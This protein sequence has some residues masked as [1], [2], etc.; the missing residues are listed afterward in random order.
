MKIGIHHREGSF[1]DGWILYC[2]TNNIPF[3]IVDAY[4]TTI[5]EDLNDCTAFL[6]HHHHTDPRDILFAK[7]L[8]YSLETKGLSVFPNFKT[9][10]HFD[11]K[12]AQKYLLEAMDAPLVPSY[13]FY[14]RKKALEWSSNTTYPKVFK[15]K[16]GASSTGVYLARNKSQA[17][18]FINKIFKRGIKQNNTFRNFLELVKGFIHNKNSFVLALKSFV[19]LFFPSEFTKIQGKE[20][21]YAYFQE[22]MPNNKFDTRLI[23]IGNKAY[24]MNRL[25]RENDFRASGSAKFDYAPIP[26][27]VLKIGFDIARK[28]GLQSVAFDFI[29][30]ENGEPLIV[31]MSY[32]FGTHGSNQCKGYWDEHFIFHESKIT[33]EAW[34]L[35]AMLSV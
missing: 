1:S 15:L 11:D 18:K 31:E 10:W 13:V 34:I 20:R 16:G 2:K 28:M 17:D 24:G 25:V 22:F 32:G 6:W 33:P 21:G 9:G 26:R 7:S 5:I 19:R 23:V 30:T 3:K 12:V 8:L 29:Y 14:S 35:E 27:E 4:S